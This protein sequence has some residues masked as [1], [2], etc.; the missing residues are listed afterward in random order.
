[1]EVTNVGYESYYKTVISDSLLPALRLH[2][3]LMVPI[4][5]ELATV[6]QKKSGLVSG[7]A[8]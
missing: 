4:D 5:V 7:G 1:M 8:L 6:R 3:H 2:N